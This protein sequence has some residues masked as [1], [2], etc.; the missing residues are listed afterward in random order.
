MVANRGGG[1]GWKRQQVI[2]LRLIGDLPAECLKD[3]TVIA[4]HNF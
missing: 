1:E 3:T 2:Q 4:I